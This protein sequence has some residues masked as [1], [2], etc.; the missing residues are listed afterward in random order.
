MKVTINF[1]EGFKN[2]KVIISEELQPLF[3]AEDISTRTQIG[4]A[5]S[6]E[7]DFKKSDPTIELEIPTRKIRTMKKLEQAEGNF[8]SVS[9]D[10]EGKVIWKVSDHPQMYM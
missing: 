5:G 8:V 1:E 2:D 4:F 9:I 7:V 6:A 3:E 10:N